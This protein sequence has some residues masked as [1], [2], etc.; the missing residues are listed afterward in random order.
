MEL[1]GASGRIP[2][3]RGVGERQ[4]FLLLFPSS[5]ACE[6]HLLGRVFSG[7]ESSIYLNRHFNPFASMAKGKNM[8]VSVPICIRN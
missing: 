5:C 3:V 1:D 8:D 7:F 4:P 6:M 2:G